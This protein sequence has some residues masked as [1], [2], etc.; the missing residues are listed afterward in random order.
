MRSLWVAS[1]VVA[2]GF[3]GVQAICAKDYGAGDFDA[4]ERHK[5]AG[6]TWMLMLMAA[7]TLLLA[8]FK[9]PML[10]LL[11]AND[12]S[13]ALARLSRECYSVFLLCFVSQGFFSLA[14]CLLFF[15]EK[16]KLL[17][18]NLILYAILLSGCALVTASGPSM[19]GYMT[20]N[21]ISVLA[22]DLYLIL[23]FLPKKTALQSR[24]DRVSPG[25]CGF[26]GFILHRPSGFHGI[27]ICRS[28]VLGGE[29][30]SALP[31]LRVSGGGRHR[32]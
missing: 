18:A 20:M 8:L 15:E 23:C 1:A 22:A 25:F 4:F 9:G 27:R 17:A 11:G 14:C 29:S 13:A 3:N 7:L 5:N 6:Y 32:L 19:T 2:L 10:D 26:P 28:P 31:L 30:V 12:G 16:R 24:H 21:E